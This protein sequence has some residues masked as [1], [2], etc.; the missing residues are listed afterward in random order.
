MIVYTT[1]HVSDYPKSK[2][3]YSQVLK[4]LG[5]STMVKH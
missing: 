3:S 1:R 5:V 4:P 2:S